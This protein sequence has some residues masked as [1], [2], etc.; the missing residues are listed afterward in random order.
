MMDNKKEQKHSQTFAVHGGQRRSSFMETSEA[1]YLTSGYVYDNAEQ[2][3]A[4][5][6]GDNEHYIYSRFSN[7]T[8]SMFEEKMAGIGGSEACWGTTTGMA[9]VFAALMCQLRAGQRVVASRTLF[10][11]CDYVI[12]ELLPRFGVDSVFVDGDDQE[13]WQKRLRRVSMWCFLKR[14]PIRRWASSIWTG[15]VAKLISMARVSL[16]IMFLRHRC[17]KIRFNG[18]RILSSILPQSI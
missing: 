14:R 7:P 8:V 11:S 2:A 1:L 4:A 9:A 3:A 17:Y 5:F 15:C 18:A 16:W 12:R 13:G 10:G 6:R